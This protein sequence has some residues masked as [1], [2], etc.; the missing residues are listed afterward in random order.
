MR[1]NRNPRRAYDENSREIAP[2]TV[3]DMRAQGETIAITGHGYRRHVVFSTDRFPATL[4]FPDIAI[5][6]YCS[7][8]GSRDVSVTRD[9]PV[10]ATQMHAEHCWRLQSAVMFSHTFIPMTVYK[11]LSINFYN[12]MAL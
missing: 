2:P 3:G 8:R 7:S 11:P 4:P 10:H 12:L 5:R 6:A 1:S 9:M